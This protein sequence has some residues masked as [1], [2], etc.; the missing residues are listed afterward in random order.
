MTDKIRVLIVDDLPET[1]ENVRKLLQFEPDMEVVGN[2]GTSAEALEQAERTHPDVVLMDINMPDRDGISTSQQ[3]IKSVPSAQII[4]MSV[5]SESDYFRRAMQA[6]ARDFLM[7]PFSG[8]QL[9]NAVRQAYTTRPAPAKRTVGETALVERSSSSSPAATSEG[10]IIAVFSPKGG[11]GCTTV[12]INLAVALAESGYRSLL[13]DGSLQFGDVGVMLNLKAMTSVIDVI[14]RLSE[15]DHDLLSSV[16]TT[17]ESGLEVLLA[18]PRPEMAELV[19]EHAMRRL[20][21][22]MRPLYD[23][24]VID[25]STSLDDVGLAMLDA[26][27]RIILLANQNLASL[28]NVIRFLNLSDEL[29]YASEKIFMVV[30]HES[31]SISISVKDIVDKLRRPVVATIPEDNAAYSAADRG[32]PLISSNLRKR[33]AAKAIGQLAEKLAVEL[34]QDAEVEMVEPDGNSRLARLFGR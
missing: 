25:T 11:A 34:A 21:Q 5:Q 23:F 32:R 4:I 16:V 14:E 26:S 22:T 6:G 27:D 10:K 30:N 12:A 17:H 18:P 33:P 20:L 24:I 7:K 19:T 1:R 3:I 2:A 9:V 15:L 31:S 13:I 28:K 8:D 29:E